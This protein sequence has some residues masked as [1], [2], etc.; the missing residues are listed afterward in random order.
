MCSADASLINTDL[1]P[2]LVLIRGIPGSG[3]ST[4]AKTSF[5]DHQLVEA[6][7]FFERD[8]KYTFDPK[9]LQKAHDWC[10]AAVKEGLA[11]GRNV[12]V[13]NT[14]TKFWE[15]KRYLGLGVPVR[16]VEATGNYQNVHDVP[17]EAV[18]RM[19][20]RYEPR[21]EMK[22]CE[23]CSGAGVIRELDGIDDCINCN[24]TGVDPLYIDGYENL[25]I[26]GD[27]ASSQ[28]ESERLAEAGRRY[29]AACERHA[30]PDRKRK[31]KRKRR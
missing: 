23:E 20:E 11:D 10:L 27:R 17:D 14:L 26:P 24:A 30:F 22:F 7:M 29:S 31:R 8:G 12:V 13:A 19:R 5:P 9:E 3:K 25:P 15:V 1:Q 4:L 28:S 16:V 2:E 6:D 18:T 21:V